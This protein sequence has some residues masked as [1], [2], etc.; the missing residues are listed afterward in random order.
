MEKKKKVI[1][2]PLSTRQ[3]VVLRDCAAGTLHLP[4]I[5]TGTPQTRS[6]MCTTKPGLFSLLLSNYALLSMPPLLHKTAAHPAAL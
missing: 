2:L 6:H 1:V 4:A 3:W 5:G